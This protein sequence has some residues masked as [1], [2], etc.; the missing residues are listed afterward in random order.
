MRYSSVR[1]V[2]LRKVDE[3]QHITELKYILFSYTQ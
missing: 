2:Q 3:R 1:K